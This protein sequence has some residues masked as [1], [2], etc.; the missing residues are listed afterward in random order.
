M[1]SNIKLNQDG[2]TR[3]LTDSAS[4][5]SVA[6]RAQ[7]DED[8]K[9]FT[10]HAFGF[11]PTSGYKTFFQIDPSF[12]LPAIVDFINIKPTGMVA[13]MV[14]PFHVELTIVASSVFGETQKT[15]TVHDIYGGHHVDIE[16]A[17]SINLMGPPDVWPKG[18]V[19]SK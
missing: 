3:E 9:R 16:P 1:D 12:V 8:G 11:N 17:G 14:T 6:Y 2:A 5:L 15:V 10:V 7:F 13:Q 19:V 4:S 18:E